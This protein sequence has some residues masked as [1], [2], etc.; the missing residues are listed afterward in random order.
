MADQ[1]VFVTYSDDLRR[2]LAKADIDIAK[3]VREELA[4]EGVQGEVTLAPDPTSTAADDRDVFLL[5]L[6]SGVAVSLVG[7]AVARV[8]D[9]V[10]QQR[11]AAME[12]QD[13]RV[14]RDGSG[15]AI[16]DA[17]GNPVYEVSTKPGAT[18]AAGKEETS[19]TAGKLLRFKFSRS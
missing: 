12:E 14:A 7:S 17:A 10:T 4:K 15:N 3:R 5:I 18:P 2:E 16:V 13:L 19:F 11:R 1:P 9:S 8:I 6:A